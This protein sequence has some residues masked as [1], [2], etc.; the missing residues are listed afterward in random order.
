MQLCFFS[1]SVDVSEVDANRVMWT[2]HTDKIVLSWKYKPKNAAISHVECS[3]S[4]SRLYD[5]YP[6]LDQGRAGDQ[7]FGRV[8]NVMKAGF[9]N[10]TLK[11]PTEKDVGY[12]Q[13]AFTSTSSQ[14]PR[15]AK[16]SLSGKII[17]YSVSTIDLFI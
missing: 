11:D 3:S 2:P 5:F 17:I 12:Y 1:V 10:L 15:K 9:F 13:C 4:K 6:A 7:Y 8:N 14:R 16:L